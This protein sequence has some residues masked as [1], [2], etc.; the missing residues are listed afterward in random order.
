[1]QYDKISVSYR[2]PKLLQGHFMICN[3]YEYDDLNG[4]LKTNEKLPV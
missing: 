2:W 4:R 3:E 1:M